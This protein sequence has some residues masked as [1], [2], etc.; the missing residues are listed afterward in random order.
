MLFYIYCYKLIVNIYVEN[1]KYNLHFLTNNIN[2]RLLGGKEMK[3]TGI[4]RKVDDL[5]RIVIP[6]EIRKKLRIREGDPL[7]IFIEKTGEIV[8]KKYAPM[9]DML[10]TVTFYADTLAATSNMCACITDT[11]TVIAASGVQRQDYIARAIS[12]DIVNVM[13]ERAIWSNGGDFKMPILEG[14]NTAKY[15]A[16]IV[17]PI[18][19]DADAIGS[20]ILFST[21]KN[22]KITN[23]E[24][25]LVQSASSFLGKQ[26]EP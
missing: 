19:C 20:V 9:G 17:A 14:E 21:N 13:E 4:V 5:G 2:K 24:Y 23:V 1:V 10:E 26:M 12:E 3:S 15:T 8:L 11:E 18:I 16:Q 6:K 22:K 7:E 25:K